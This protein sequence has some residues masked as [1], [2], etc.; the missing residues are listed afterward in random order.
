MRL[1]AVHPN[2]ELY[3]SDRSFARA[4]SAIREA[5]PEAEI[6]V[7]LPRDGPI[8]SLPVFSKVTVQFDDMWIPR[9]GDLRQL[10]KLPAFFAK[11]LARIVRAV[12]TM[13]RYDLVYINT[14]I[15]LDY[16]LAAT[17]VRTPSA[18]HVR[19]IVAGRERSVF[20]SILA[21]TRGALIFNSQ[22]TRASFDL[23]RA[24]SFVVY[25]GTDV[26]PALENTRPDPGPLRILVIGRLNAWKGQEVLVAAIARMT[27]EQRAR[28][29]V[30]IV[31]SVFETLD[32]F[33]AQ[34][35]TQIADA[36]LDTTISMHPFTDDPGQHYAWAD[37]VVVPST[38]PEPFGRVA[39]EAMSYKAAVIATAHGGPVEIVDDGVTGE[40]VA[41]SDADGLAR[42]LLRYLDDPT[43]ARRQGE[44][45]YRRFLDRFTN[46]ASDK[47]VVAAIE[48]I[49]PFEPTRSAAGV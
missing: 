11:G 43:L 24:K 49:Y 37:I 18:I 34:I 14:I 29:S 10:S 46:E 23:P 42:A 27:A 35:A 15:S 7:L 13:R 32:H 1:L 28:V 2:F 31:G 16:L 47:A 9:R 26:P 41:P 40:L 19:E 17:M 20:R 36:G 39:I 30:R 33:R 25:N 6:T 22:A 48:A 3:G 38:R 12:R 44:A 5:H 8:T 21:R 4:I 45:G